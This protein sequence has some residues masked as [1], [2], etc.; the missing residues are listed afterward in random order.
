MLAKLAAVF[1]LGAALAADAAVVRRA[2]DKKCQTIAELAIATPGFE[3]LVTAVTAAGLV[4]TFADA[5][6]AK[7]T[8][9]APTDDAFADV[10]EDVIALLLKPEYVRR[11]LW[12]SQFLT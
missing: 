1:A 2:D 4:D 12:L 10:D 6:G 11:F 8:V 7:L 5:D 3:T 9:F